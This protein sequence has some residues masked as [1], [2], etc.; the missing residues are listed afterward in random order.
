MQLKFFTIPVMNPEE[1]EAELNSFL[2]THRVLTVRKELVTNEGKTPFWAIA[3]EYLV[4]VSARAKKIP[5]IDFESILASYHTKP[6]KGLPIGNLTSQHFANF[7][8]GQ[9]D[10]HA[11]EVLRIRGYLRYMDDFLAFGK[12]RDE[13]R[14]SLS[15]IRDYLARELCL[16][17]KEG[18]QLKRCTAGISF[19]G[20]RIFPH[21]IGLTRR[22]R[23]RFITK[24]KTYES[25][26][27]RGQLSECELSRRMQAVTGFTEW[28]D[29][30]GFR[31][32]A[33]AKYG[34]LP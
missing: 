7:Y 8:L 29:A 17:L 16:E 14:T 30:A 26:H 25:L 27:A 10:H 9:M 33:I 28:A 2:R 24:L 19:L 3:A 13:L 12:S 11:K 18:V 15:H 5:S 4:G 20:Y 6:G 22:S 34:V 21:R 1:S 32:D 23:Q 31:R